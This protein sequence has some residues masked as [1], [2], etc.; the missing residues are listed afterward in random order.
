MFWPRRLKEVADCAIAVPPNDGG[1]RSPK[2]VEIQQ[3]G[4][5]SEEKM[6]V[7][8]EMVDVVRNADSCSFLESLSGDI[9]SPF[10]V[11]KLVV[12]HTRNECSYSSESN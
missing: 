4:L 12:V 9:P 3:Y 1:V 8:F 2:L 5:G 11:W 6:G 7:S 10:C